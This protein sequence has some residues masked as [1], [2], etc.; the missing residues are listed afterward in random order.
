MFSLYAKPRFKIV[1]AKGAQNMA[2]QLRA[3][4]TLREDLGVL[5]STHI[6]A[7]NELGLHLQGFRL[8]S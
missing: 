3:L 2:Q 1:N 6:I 4:A 7:H 8:F 5:P